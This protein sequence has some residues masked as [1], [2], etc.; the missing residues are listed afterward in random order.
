KNNSLEAKCDRQVQIFEDSLQKF[1]LWALEMFDAS[2]K[3]PSGIFQGNI[4]DLGMYDQCLKVNATVGNETIRGKHCM[5][6]LEGNFNAKKLPIDP[7]MSVCLP[8]TCSPKQVKEK[9]QKLMNMAEQF[10]GGREIR[11]KNATCSEVDDQPWELGAKVTLG[12]FGG[13]VTFLL[14]CTFCKLLPKIISINSGLINTLGKFSFIVNGRNI[15]STKAPEENLTIIAGLKV[16]GIS[17][18]VLGHRYFIT[19]HGSVVNLADTEPWSR[20]WQATFIF[21]FPQYSVDTFLTITGVLTSY[22]FLKEMAKGCKFNIFLYY[23]HR[24]LRLTPMFMALISI[25]TFLLPKLGSGALWQTITTTESD[26]CKREWWPMLLYVHNF[27]YTDGMS[28]LL[29]TW[30]LALDMQLFWV[31]PLIIYPLYKKPKLGLIILSAAI[32]ASVITP[33]V[34]AAI[35]KFS[36]AFQPKDK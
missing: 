14:I 7:I 23:L 24:Y 20:S 25:T 2:T 34:V 29:H 8:A 9:M 36:T 4:K 31:S 27:V 12:V 1:E 6:T 15:L 19:S 13:L 33:A 21:T 17:L 16:Y 10:L 18:I 3:I 5:Y 11:V 28:C 35:K 22:L 26:S 32:A 30:Y